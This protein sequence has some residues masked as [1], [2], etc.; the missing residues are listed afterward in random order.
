MTQYSPVSAGRTILAFILAPIIPVLFFVVPTAIK[1]FLS[2]AERFDL[3]S[4][5]SLIVQ[6][7]AGISLSVIVIGV[8]VWMISEAFQLRSRLYYVCVGF[9]CGSFPG[10]A[11]VYL[12]ASADGHSG[13]SLFLLPGTWAGMII[14]CLMG[15]LTM[16]FFHT[17]A[18]RVKNV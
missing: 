4:W 15:A 3:G 9:V 5:L 2:D 13:L 10:F 7:Y 8:L 6:A 11:L 14:I 16:L 18:F 1:L 17:V 12:A